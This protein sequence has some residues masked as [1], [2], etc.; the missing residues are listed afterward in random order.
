[1]RY[2]L[3]IL[4]LLVGCEDT[5]THPPSNLIGDWKTL[6]I[7]YSDGLEYELAED[8]T[9]YYILSFKDDENYDNIF[10]SEST[11]SLI[12]EGTWSREYYNNKVSFINDVNTIQA[13]YV[14]YDEEEP[15]RLRLTFITESSP[16]NQI[17]Y[18]RISN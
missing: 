4:L 18:R 2:L 7:I 13:E 1:M 9:S 6:T 11:S 17:V 3:I 16:Y 14:I 5:L 10:Y 12:D 15:D 8:P